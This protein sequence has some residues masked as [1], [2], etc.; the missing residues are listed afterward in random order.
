MILGRVRLF[1]ARDDVSGGLAR[2]VLGPGQDVAVLQDD[3]DGLL[4]DGAGLFET[5]LED[6]H[7]ELALEEEVLELPALGLRDVL[8]LVAGVLGGGGEAV[9]PRAS[10]GDGVPVG[11][12]G[13]LNGGHFVAVVSLFFL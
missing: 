2:A 7:E 3:G 1:E 10:A 12:I 5:L 8:G 11:R 9:P 6:A 4:L 13:L